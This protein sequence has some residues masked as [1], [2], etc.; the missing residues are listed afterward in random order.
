MTKM[1]S[2]KL[3][4]Y[5]IFALFVCYTTRFFIITKFMILIL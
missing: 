1:Y 4:S 3:F 2:V 5:Y